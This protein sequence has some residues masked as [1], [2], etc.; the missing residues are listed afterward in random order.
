MSQI[1]ILGIPGSIRKNSYNKL[2]LKATLNLLPNNAKMEIFEDLQLI[3]PFNQDEE[4]NPPEIVKELKKKIR[5]ADAII[6][7][8]P[9]YNRSIPGVLKN[10][11]DWVTRPYG[12]NPFDGKVVGIMSASIGMLGGSLAHYHLV[13]IM[14]YLNARIVNQ[15]EVFVSFAQQK[16]DENGNLNDEMAKKFI[17][18]LLERIVEEVLLVRSKKELTV[19]T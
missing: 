19:T 7:A 9:E 8:T 13:Q 6:F 15:P 16:F 17:R 4:N 10:L 18:I 1:N 3:P 5:E 12:D 11:I 14:E 2:L